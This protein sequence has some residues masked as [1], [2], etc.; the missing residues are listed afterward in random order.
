MSTTLDQQAEP[1][2]TK[3]ASL[4]KTSS[5]SVRSPNKTWP[6]WHCVFQEGGAKLESWTVGHRYL[7]SCNGPAIRGLEK[8]KLHFQFPKKEQEEYTLHILQVKAISPHQAQFVVTGYKPGD[9]KLEGLKITDGKSGFI[10]TPLQWKVTSVLEDQ[11]QPVPPFGPFQLSFP[12]WYYGIWVLLGVLVIGYFGRLARKYYVRKKLIES[13]EIHSTALSPFNQ[14]NKDIRSLLRTTDLEEK[15]QLPVFVKQMEDMF[16]LF[17]IRQL[18]VPAQDWSDQDILQDIRKRHQTVYRKSSS[19]IHGLFCEFK[20]AQAAQ[21]K[22][23]QVDIEQLL[24]MTRQV[25][26]SVEV[27]HRESKK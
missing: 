10:S 24:E 21:D 14:L 9:F 4:S 7:L 8:E 20:K 2:I 1:F 17:L 12:W 23:S 6:E 18:L 13:L 15:K 27:S 5:V 26:N 22:L 11:A 3:Q 19:K 16:R 25:A